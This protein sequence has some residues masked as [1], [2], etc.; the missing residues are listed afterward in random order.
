MYDRTAKKIVIPEGTK[1][2]EFEQFKGYEVV[3]EIVLPDSIEVINMMAFTGCKSLKR[4]NLPNNLSLLEPY[5]FAGCENLE[6]IT[7]PPSL[8][9]LSAGVFRD[10]KKLKHLNIHNNI[11]YIDEYALN[12]CES[13]EDFDIP[14][15]VTSLGKKAL[16]RCKKIKQVHIPAKLD[17]IEVG[18]L[19]LMDSLEQIIVDDGNEKYFT[20]DDNS[21]LISNDG[22]IIQYA[23]NCDREEFASGYY[24]KTCK[25]RENNLGEEEPIESYE[26]IYNIADYAFAGAKKLKKLILPSETESIGTKTFLN[27][28]NLKELEIYHTPCG[29]TLLLSIFGSFREEANIPFEKITIHEGVTTL[30][31]NM[32]EILKNAREVFLPTTLEHIGKNVFSKSVH[33]TK[34]DIPKGIKTIKPNAFED[35]IILNFADFGSIKGSEFNMLQAKTSE[36]YYIEKHERDNIRIFALNDGTYYVKIDDYDIVRVNRYEIIKMSDSSHIM[37]DNP[38]KFIEYICDLLHINGE[39]SHIMTGIWT[40]T[41][42]EETFSK[43]ANDLDYVKNIA[44]HKTANAIREII[45]NSGIYDEFLFSG[46]MMKKMGKDEIIKLLENYNTSISRFFRLCQVDENDDF[47]N[48]VINVDNLIEYCN[49]LEQ[50]GKYDKFL[51]NPIFFQKLSHKNAE[52]LIK[53]FNKN[54]KHILQNSE[55]L[56]DHYGNNLNDLITFCNALGVFSDDEI[57]SQRLSTFINEKIL[58]EKLPNGKDN[59]H[60]VVGNDIHTIFG[61]I[62]PRDEVDYEFIKLFIENYDQLIELEKK[63]SGIIAMIYNAFRDISKTSTSHRGSQ[64]HLKVTLDK[65]IDYFL[66]RSFEGVTEENKELATVLQSYYSE[67]YALSVGEMIVKQSQEAPRN[68][69]SK[70]NYSEDGDPIYSYDEKEDLYEKNLKGFSY[71][72]LPKQDYDNLIL[73]KY[74]NCCAHILGA[75]AGIM[76]ASMILDNCQNLV[77][78]NIKGEIIAKMTIYIN[79]EQG[80]AVFNTAEVNFIYRTDS[81]INEIYEAF[82]RG[83]NA[84]VDKYN[85]NNAI[86]ISLVSIGKYRNVIKYNLGNEEIKVLDTPNYSTYGYYAGEQSVG[87]YDGDAKR[88]QILVLRKQNKRNLDV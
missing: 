35:N 20:E 2:I 55:T 41:R 4:I 65:C 10:C 79:R 51:Y 30:P 71:H 33:L 8:H 31:E 87:T 83:V 42:L 22:I 76:R 39:S 29:K 16:M 19:A 75:G 36:D 40:D 25:T 13:L 81:D 24:I 21:V 74:C 48:I 17:T 88:K 62:K 60:R 45:N 77:I 46:M 67:S 69:F 84:F 5:A 82:M 11:N 14:S 26:M 85:E 38:D 64:R 6:E 72:W 37:K 59:E 28:D 32:V 3:E 54:I 49:L 68:I 61:E 57:I 15:N 44:E 86:P 63:F 73:G 12:N 80:Y 53:K 23:I 58:N 70:I 43:F 47:D 9:Y 7:I 34:L 78:R 52:L 56:D 66:T 1:Q 18:A 50:Y 27:C